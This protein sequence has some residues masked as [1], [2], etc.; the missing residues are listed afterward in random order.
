MTEPSRYEVTWGEK[1]KTMKNQKSYLVD[2][3]PWAKRAACP[4]SRAR[5]CVLLAFD[6]EV[7]VSG[8][9]LRDLDGVALRVERVECHPAALEPLAKVAGHLRSVR[10]VVVDELAPDRCDSHQVGMREV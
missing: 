7:P 3:F 5:P 2:L 8:V 4:G 10:D 9:I 1:G 6:T